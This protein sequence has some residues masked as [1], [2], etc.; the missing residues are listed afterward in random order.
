MS[1]QNTPSN[2]PA[3]W[4]SDANKDFVSNKGWKSGDDAIT[5][6]QNLEKLVG[7]D[8]AGRTIVLPKDANDAEGIKAFRA[9]LGVPEK[10]EDYKLPVPEGDDAA[11]A[12]KAAEWFLKHGV[13]R[14]AAVGIMSDMNAFFHEMLKN[15]TATLQAESDRQLTELKTKWGDKFDQNSELARRFLRANGWDDAYIKRYEETFGTADMLSRFHN[16]GSKMGEH[17]FA[18]GDKGGGG[19]GITPAAAKQQIAELRQKRLDNQVTEKDFHEQMAK[20]GPI[21]EKA[22]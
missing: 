4:F 6:F 12:G 16:F 8:K 7:A 11:F 15:D 14:E 2:D 22:A 21:A 9:K 5:S 18:E 1:E 17:A 3:P 20:L 13:P 19:F 10:P